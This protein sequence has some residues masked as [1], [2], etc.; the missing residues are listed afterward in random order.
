MQYV[1][2]LTPIE[3]A[4]L[5]GVSR[6]AVLQAVA[7]QRLPPFDLHEPLRWSVTPSWESAVDA[8][9]AARAERK[10]RKSRKEVA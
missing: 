3:L 4:W 1:K 6:S 8:W 10:S 2:T 9:L 5:C 7:L